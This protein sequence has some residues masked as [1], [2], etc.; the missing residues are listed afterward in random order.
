MTD[1]TC[2]R[3]SRR[4]RH[5]SRSHSTSGTPQAPKQEYFQHVD[6]ASLD[7]RSRHAYSAGR[8]FYAKFA[9]SVPG[10]PSPVLAA[11]SDPPRS[12]SHSHSHRARS[13]GRPHSRR[14]GRAIGRAKKHGKR[15]RSVS[16]TRR[17]RSQRHEASPAG[18]A[19]P[20]TPEDCPSPGAARVSEQQPSVGDTRNSAFALTPKASTATIVPRATAAS[21][22]TEAASA[23]ARRRFS[24]G[25]PASFTST[26]GR[27]I[28]NPRPVRTANAT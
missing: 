24:L 15:H 22:M 5:R 14:G 9:S 2:Y 10:S 3:C 27:V 28:V 7:R 16:H 11:P 1:L 25:E 23:A 21:S 26:D 20:S 13:V 17:T 18:Q 4:R 12:H 6:R 8:D 19:D